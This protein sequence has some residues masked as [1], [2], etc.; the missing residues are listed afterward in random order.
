[1][2]VSVASRSV[3]SPAGI[4][5]LGRLALGFIDGGTQWLD[6]AIHDAGA[7][8]HF[9]DESALVAGVQAGLHA[10]PFAL[11]PTLGLMVSPVK[12]M[13]IGVSDLRSLAAGEAG[14]KSATVSAQV[15]RILRAHG[16]ATQADLASV[17]PFLDGLKVAAAPVFQCP[18]FGD[19]LALLELMSADGKPAADLQ[20]EAAAFAVEQGRTPREFVDYYRAY[21]DHA[22]ALGA[23]ADTPKKRAASARAALDTLLPLLFAALDCPRVDGLVAPWEVSAAIDQW[24]TMG[25]RVGFARL[26][27]GVGQVIANG[28]FKEQTGAEA[29]Q[30]VDTY[31]A[32]AQALLSSAEPGPGLMGQDGASVRF[33]VKAAG[34]E[35]IVD[36]GPDGIISL[37]S[38]RAGKRGTANG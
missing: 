5:E 9:A 23:Q 12:L 21:L 34:G 38:Y 32:A 2:T 29:R 35:A 14:G 31:L 22:A 18:G 20:A 24:L 27:L 33:P 16:L 28:G 8:Y 26:S 7:R 1:M 4:S 36:L 37:G 17:Q 25:R 10:S 13:T 11:L 15:K 3:S 30:I 6:W 19:R